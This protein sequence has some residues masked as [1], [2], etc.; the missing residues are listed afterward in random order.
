MDYRF[1]PK[2]RNGR[3]AHVVC[4]AGELIAEIGRFQRWGG[5]SRFPADDISKLTNAEAVLREIWDLRE[6]IAAC[7]S[8][9]AEHVG[10]TRVRWLREDWEIMAYPPQH[11]EEKP[12]A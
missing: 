7:E 10:A 8:D 2:D 1:L 3:L 9:L 4:E 12:S 6:A 5:N 11:Q